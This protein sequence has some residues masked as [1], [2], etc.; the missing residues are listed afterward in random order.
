VH[1]HTLHTAS[2]ATRW[3]KN[4][5]DSS[6]RSCKT[7]LK[8]KR[9][10]KR[11]PHATPASWHPWTSVASFLSALGIT[12]V[13]S[14][15]DC[16]REEE[17]NCSN[18]FPRSVPCQRLPPPR[19]FGDLPS[20]VINESCPFSFKKNGKGG[21]M[22][23]TNHSWNIPLIEVH[24]ARVLGLTLKEVIELTTLNASTP[25]FIYINMNI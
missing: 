3:S 12:C 6:T 8:G 1:L 11:C 17:K 15:W 13:L 2:A 22:A 14:S 16:S 10:M 25:D 20:L 19:L 23:R 7:S 18:F 24:V 9:R 5:P 21:G 4:M